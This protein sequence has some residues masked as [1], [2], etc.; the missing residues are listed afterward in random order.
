MTTPIVP[1]AEAKIGDHVYTWENAAGDWGGE[2]LYETVDPLSTHDQYDLAEIG[3]LTRKRW[4]LVA[5][6]EIDTAL[7][8]DEEEPGAT[9]PPRPS[10]TGAGSTQ[11]PKETP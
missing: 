10:P 7:P 3:P 11:P 6:D 8:D 2:Y 1:Y 5:I 9:P 4:Q